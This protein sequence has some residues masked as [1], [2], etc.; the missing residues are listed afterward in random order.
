[1]AGSGAA[2]TMLVV[3]LSLV[4]GVLA[5][6]EA[7]AKRV[8]GIDV[9]RFQGEIDWERVGETNVR[10]AFVQ[11]SRGGGDDC[12]VAPDRCGADEFYAA[13]YEGARVAG[14]PV[15]AYH[16][17]F[18]DG[19]GRKSARRDARREANVFLGEVGTLR[20]GDLLPALDVETPFGGLNQRSL[21][22]WLH[23]WL[24]RVRR[25]LGERPIIYTN[26]SSWQAT[27]DTKKFARRG[28]QLW[29][30]NW[31]VASPSVPADNWNGE[32]WTIWQY[33]SSGRVNGIAGRV[34]RNHLSVGLDAISAG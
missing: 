30:A 11:A 18:A 16:R 2:K 25:K 5:P 31:G 15:G 20:E 29:V 10:F 34:D 3:G 1:M 33:T 12:A 9:S 32:G 19:R 27:G 21:R 13:N 22:A 4:V 26:T 24:K 28:H 8:K 23:A 7:A 6:G 14:I 17:A